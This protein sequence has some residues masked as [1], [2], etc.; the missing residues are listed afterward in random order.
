MKSL[1]IREFRACVGSLDELAEQMGEIRI[2][3]HGK[4]ILRVL[5]IHTKL[6]RPLHQE[7]RQKMGQLEISSTQRV[8]EDR[9]ER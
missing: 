4:P 8:R 2:T 3:R 5:P 1:T 9:D 6:K 7:L